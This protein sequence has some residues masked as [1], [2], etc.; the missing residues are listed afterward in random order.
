MVHYICTH[1]VIVLQVSKRNSLQSLNALTGLRWKNLNK[2]QK[3]GRSNGTYLSRCSR[4]LNFFLQSLDTKARLSLKI[5]LS[6]D[7]TSFVIGFAEP[8]ISRNTLNYI[9][10][11]QNIASNELPRRNSSDL[12]YPAVVLFVDFHRNF[13][14]KKI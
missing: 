5:L 3:E 8:M 10:N 1:L 11:K 7:I 12:T 13:K 6:M 9:Y 4:W 2:T 14:T